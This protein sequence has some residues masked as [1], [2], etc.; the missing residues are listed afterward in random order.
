MNKHPKAE[1]QRVKI[2]H[3]A[4]IERNLIKEA[5]AICDFAN[6][7]VLPVARVYNLPMDKE[8]ILRYC[9]QPSEMQAQYVAS[10]VKAEVPAGASKILKEIIEERATAKAEEL[11]AIPGGTAYTHHPEFL[12]IGEGGALTYDRSAICKAADVYLTDPGQL[13]AFRRHQAAVEAMNDFFKGKA[14]DAWTGLRGFFW[15]DNAGNVVAAE[16]VDYKNFV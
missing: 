11:A 6:R 1:A 8:A 13:A 15:L 4:L 7:E 5:E 9:R 12:T 14:P 10:V 3:S 2:G 16:N